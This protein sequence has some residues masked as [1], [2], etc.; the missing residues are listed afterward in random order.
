M[1]HTHTPLT[2]SNPSNS[3]VRFARQ[4]GPGQFLRELVQNS[5]EAGATRVEVFPFEFDFNGKKV[6]R[7]CVV[8]NGHGMTS[9]EMGKY[10]G[11]Y[12]SSGKSKV[13]GLHDNFG[14]GVKATCGES[15]P[16]GIVFVSWKQGSTDPG[17]M[18]WFSK[19]AGVFGIRH[20]PYDIENQDGSTSTLCYGETVSLSDMEESYPSGFEGVS[21][22]CLLDNRIIK[23]TINDDTGGTHGTLVML[24]GTSIDC[25]TYVSLYDSTKPTSRREY[26]KYLNSRYWSIDINVRLR[27]TACDGSTFTVRGLKSLL[28]FRSNVPEVKFTKEY[29]GL[30]LPDGSHVG[31]FITYGS[32]VE[33][34]V[35]GGLPK[36]RLSDCGYSTADM[37]DGLFLVLYKNELYPLGRGIR[38]GVNW[39][40]TDSAAL[41][42]VKI[43]VMPPLGGAGSAGIY[44]N[45]TRDGLLWKTAN[46]SERSSAYT[47]KYV[48]E[49]YINNMPECLKQLLAEHLAERPA[50][51]FTG[52]D[53]EIDALRNRFGM[54]SLRG[55]VCMVKENT[56]GTE[57][58]LP[59]GKEAPGASGIATGTGNPRPPAVAPSG[60]SKGIS[61]STGQ[62]TGSS[63]ARKAIPI[64]VTPHIIDESD[65]N[66]SSLKA[67]DSGDSDYVYPC[68]PVL[69]ANGG[70]L[71]VLKNHELFATSAAHLVKDYVNGDS[72]YDAILDIVRSE[73]VRNSVRVCV[74]YLTLC[75]T[76][77]RAFPLDMDTLRLQL[78]VSNLGVTLFESAIRTQIRS[79]LKLK[80]NKK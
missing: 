24:C 57:S 53:A 32:G 47:A 11:K 16:Y 9:Q 7:L 36:D 28:G 23:D 26:T 71:Y 22:H 33:F 72:Y 56:Q 69:T 12:N 30:Q 52:L 76:N 18:L 37:E 5:L 27:V 55:P 66:Y 58:F 39:G 20:I 19:E 70:S 29:S 21:W 48:Q 62:S 44:P 75:A 54:S 8:D 13:S 15:N 65:P 61:S 67:P 80:S 31:T 4:V 10:I 6:T 46:D 77:R 17:N 2:D 41:K 64:N 51:D 63:V 45:E 25:D 40:I 38:Q 43:I 35:A 42:S 14:I 78:M 79:E 73:H 1:S 3:L 68:G 60:A 74:H 49:Y 59:T 50:N 34:G